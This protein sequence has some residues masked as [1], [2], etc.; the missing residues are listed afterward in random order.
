MA[1]GDLVLAAC[2]AVGQPGA[3]GGC[4]AGAH[5][6]ALVAADGVEG[7]GRVIGR[8]GADIAI[9][10]KT[11]LDQSLEAV[12]DASISRRAAAADGAQPR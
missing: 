12:A 10:H 11:Q 2:I 1:D 4:N 3:A 6:H 8:D 5:Q 7:Q 9:G